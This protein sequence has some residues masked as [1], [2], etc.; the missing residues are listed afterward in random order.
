MRAEAAIFRRR[1]LLRPD[2]FQNH[3]CIHIGAIP[4]CNLLHFAVVHMLSPLSQNFCPQYTKIGE[5]ICIRAK[6]QPSSFVALLCG[7][8]AVYPGALHRA[9]YAMPQPLVFVL[10]AA[11]QLLH[12]LTLRMLVRGAAAVKHG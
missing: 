11:Q 2:L 7:A 6:K 1:I 4:L 10:Q 12:F 9:E 5:K 3:V 8:V